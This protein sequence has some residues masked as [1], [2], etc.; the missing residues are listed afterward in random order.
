MH[1]AG[2]IANPYHDDCKN[3][4]ITILL[5]CFCSFLAFTAGMPGMHL[6]DMI[7][8]IDNDHPHLLRTLPIPHVSTSSHTCLQ[9]RTKISDTGLDYPEVVIVSI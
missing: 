4:Y 5:S 3:N 6:C 8:R 1:P 7:A 2:A 9:Y